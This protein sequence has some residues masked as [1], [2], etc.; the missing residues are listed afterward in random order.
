MDQSIIFLVLEG[1]VVLLL[2]TGLGYYIRQ[3]LARQ[4]AGSLEAK[5][6]KR[7]QDVKQET[8][9][10]VKNA[11]SKAG[12]ITERAQKDID[13][14][15]SEFLKAEQ[16][17]LEREKLLDGKLESFDKKEKEVEEKGEKLKTVK[18]QLDALR[19][20]AETKLEK[21]AGLSREDAK[22]E[23]LALVEMTAEKDLV[24]RIK[25]LEETG[26]DTLN[27]KA[28]EIVTLAIQKCAVAHT[29]ELST[30]TITLASEELKG[31]IIGKEGRNIKT[32]EKITGVEL[33]LDES[34]DTVV[35]SC[36]NPVRRQIAKLALDKL[37]A[38]GRI[39]P[40]KIEEKVAEA[41]AEISDVIKK[42]G[43]KA[44]YD[45]NLLAMNDKL[46]QILGRLHYRTSYGQNVLQ[47]SMEVAL[48]AQTI[49]EELGADGQVA[50]RGGLFHDIGKAL[51]QQIEGSHIEIGI[52]ILEKYGESSAVVNAMKSHH[53]DY[54]HES[55]E[56]VIVTIAD[57]ISASRPGA[58][59][60]SIEN[61]LQRLK[62]LED[63]ANK[64]E[65]VEKAYAIQAGREIRVFV[66]ADKID[67]MG[68]AKV[69]RQ[70]AANIEEELKYPGEIKVT[71]IR[72]NRVIEY[73]R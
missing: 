16:V 47:H 11:Q 22:K 72:E 68:V 46:M 30:T 70:I 52:K 26:R 12:E 17:L 14:R 44:M 40:A 58:R 4:R 23:L 41:T 66:K 8:A 32:F 10:L 3:S 57:A 1:I 33:I 49:A 56:S 62:A 36:F 45:M 19:A 43:E 20:E 13:Q 28:R 69:A 73:A 15:R 53:G 7:V 42:A 35:I 48:I 60:D 21:V 64:F 29:Q 2:G 18:E 34:P 38:D 25:K 67:D 71:V 9:D 39:Q 31:R 54:P 51:D 63:I 6:Q 59:K 61:Y 5:L 27:T 37:I 55:I 24:S 50:K 65:G